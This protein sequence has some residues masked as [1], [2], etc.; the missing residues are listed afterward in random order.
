MNEI[1]P[2]LCRLPCAGVLRKRYF[3]RFFHH[4]S[5]KRN[6][7][8]PTQVLL[9]ENGVFTIHQSVKENVDFS[10]PIS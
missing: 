9:R 5:E 10:N 4:F 1:A 8:I 6:R 2:P 3:Y 7:G